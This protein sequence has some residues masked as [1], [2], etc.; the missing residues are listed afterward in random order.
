M[1]N[2]L[3]DLRHGFRLVR[4]APGFAAIVVLTL[5]LAIGGNTAIF[6]LVNTVFFRTLPFSQPERVLR[7]LDSLRGPD[8]HRSTYGMRSQN[9][10]AVQQETQI[11]ASSVATLGVSR[12]A[13]PV[14]PAGP[15][16]EGYSARS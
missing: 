13:D 10:L 6:S 4:K 12:A 14:L 2:L 15:A 3:Q 16:G 7:L 9:V 11:F 1:H 8:G 5:A